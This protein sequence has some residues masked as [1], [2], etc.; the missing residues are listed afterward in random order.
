M[1]EGLN[2]VP[3][4]KLSH[5]YGDASDVPDLIRSLRGNQAEADVALHEL[6]GNIWHQ[7][8]VYE[9]TSYAVPFLV[10]VAGDEG[11]PDRIG[12]LAL[13]AA[14]ATGHPFTRTY[15]TR[16]AVEEKFDQ[17]LKIAKSDDVEI[18]LAALHVL[19]QFPNRAEAVGK[20]IL[21]SLKPETDSLYRAGHLLL[22]GQ[23]KDSSTE[24]IKIIFSSFDASETERIAAMLALALMNYRLMPVPE[25]QQMTAELNMEAIE[26]HFS[27][28]PWDALGEIDEEEITA[29]FASFRI[30]DD[31]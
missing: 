5:A 12:V 30:K 17:I 3:W 20:I 16:K 23:V 21:S 19:A 22:L 6:F 10:E 27:G 26:T 11:T 7:G 31:D 8:T 15:N 25:Y 29:Y 9:S 28:L 24:S 4:H 14:I 13:I 1:L 2:K 18:R